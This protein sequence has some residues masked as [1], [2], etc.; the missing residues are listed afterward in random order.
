[1]G[2]NKTL[3][4]R[5][6]NKDLGQGKIM[7]IKIIIADLQEIKLEREYIFQMMFQYVNIIQLMILL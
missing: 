3:L 2:L 4:V 1:M 7:F 5:L 6:F